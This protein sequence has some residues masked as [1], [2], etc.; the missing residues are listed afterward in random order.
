[1]SDGGNEKTTSKAQ[2]LLAKAE[3]VYIVDNAFLRRQFPMLICPQ[4][5]SLEEFYRQIGSKYVSEVVKKDFEVLGNTFRD[6]PLTNSFA[7][8]IKERRPLL[9]SPSITS[10]PLVKNASAI[11]DNLE[12][13]QADSIKA[14]YSFERSSKMINVT[15][16]SKFTKKK[17]IAIFITNDFEMFD[18]GSCIGELILQHC[19]LKDSFFI[20]S[21]LE[22]SVATLRNRGFP[23]DRIIKPNPPP[24]VQAEE[25]LQTPD[26]RQNPQKPHHSDT[27]GASATDGTTCG[28]NK[29]T[30]SNGNDNQNDVGGFDTILQSMFP[31]CSQSK[32]QEMLGSNPTKEKAAEV[33]N[34]LS[35]EVIDDSN[36]KEDVNNAAAVPNAKKEK[37]R[38]RYLGKFREGLGRMPQKLNKHLGGGGQPNF[39]AKAETKGREDAAQKPNHLGGDGGGGGGQCPGGGSIIHGGGRPNFDG[40]GE[41]KGREDASQ[42]LLDAMLQQSVQSSRP[43]DSSGVTSTESQVLPEGI[44]CGKDG[45]EILPAQNTQ[46][47]KGPH[48]TYKTRN[49]IRVMAADSSG[50]ASNA[51]EAI[52]FLSNNFECVETF[53][54]VIGHLVQIFQLKN[55]STSIYFDGGGGT[56]AFNSNKSFHFNVRFFHAL[57]R[58]EWNSKT[59]YSYWFTVFCHELAHNLVTAHNKEHGKYTESLVILYLPRLLDFLSKNGIV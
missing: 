1:M 43:V 59:C 22:A 41:I 13:H 14:I 39:D 21:L 18:V 48:G 24:V 2:Y 32:I 26:N 17:S 15:C 19:E 16:C 42:K 6:T 57:H 45:C 4:D 12:I 35:E 8:R 51:N 25:E 23:V 5:Q 40:E 11:L 58:Q 49:G 47:F 46:P 3:D 7:E 33:A 54:V 55:S 31:H 29:P 20:T 50:S 53:S 27:D 30:Q 34:E 52:D 37:K 28:T 10:R 36:H 38:D 56:I 44:N 9:L